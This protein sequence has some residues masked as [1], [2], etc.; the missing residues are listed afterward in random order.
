MYDL[1]YIDESQ[2]TNALAAKLKF[3]PESVVKMKYQWFIEPAIDEIALDFSN[4]YGIDKN[5]AKQ[6]LRVGGYSI[7]LTIDTNIQRAAEDVIN[8]PSNYKSAKLPLKLKTYTT[9]KATKDN[10]NPQKYD[11]P[12][13]AAVIYDYS[14]GQMRAIVGGRGAH[15]RLSTNRATAVPRQPGSSIKPLA[16]YGPSI[17]TKLVTAATI[18]SDTKMSPAFIASHNWSPHN[19]ET[20]KFSGNVTVRNAI[21]SSINMVAIKLADELNPDPPSG[22][23]HNEF[24][25]SIDYLQNKFHLSTIVTT[26]PN[27]DRGLSP[28]AL[29]ALT[30]GVY[31]YE[32]AAAY[33]VFANR[34][35]YTS[36]VMYTKIVDNMGNDVLDSTSNKSQSISP[37]AAFVMVDMMKGVV[38]GGTGTRA[39]FGK[40]PAAGKTGTATDN[41]NLWFCGVTPYYSGAVWLGHDIPNVPLR[42]MKSSDAAKM[43]GKIMKIAHAN[44][45]VKDFVKPN[46]IVSDPVCIDSGK[47]PNDLC[48]KDSSGQ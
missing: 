48:Y 37:Q 4:R 21:K 12:Q 14:T 40:M 30:Q 39:N 10:P 38:S 11:Q 28:L 5:D 2:Y 47:S 9:E 42:G 26:G 25:T 24:N 31:P 13:A 32:M 7:Y 33:G 3:M 35:V 20:N 44:L 45:K 34:G 8:D 17:D 15:P 41:T 18:I 46:N 27:S 22:V 19:Y 29:G 36:P 43:W 1:K 23:L 16:V 6:K